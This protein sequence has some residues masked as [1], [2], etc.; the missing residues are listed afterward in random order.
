MGD[1]MEGRVGRQEEKAGVDTQSPAWGSPR[2]PCGPGRVWHGQGHFWAARM[3]RDW[4]TFTM[5]MMRRPLVS[6]KVGQKR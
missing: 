5:A 3:E 4:L 6:R 1:R 2:V